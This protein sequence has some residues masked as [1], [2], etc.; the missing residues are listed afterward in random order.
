MCRF[1]K[2]SSESSLL[3]P[4]KSLFREAGNGERTQ[5]VQG[6]VRLLGGYSA[7][8]VCGLGW[9]WGAGERISSNGSWRIVRGQMAHLVCLS[10]SG[11]GFG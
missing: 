5:D 7:G 2:A 10:Q 1:F 9:V 11:V 6:L 8:C 3:Q 4:E